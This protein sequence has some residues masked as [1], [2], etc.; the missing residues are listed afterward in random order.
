MVSIEHVDV[1]QKA[2]I[3]QFID[4]PYRLYEG[5]SQWVPPFRRDVAE[6]LDPARHP[7]YEHSTADFFL[8]IRDGRVVGRIAALENRNYNR[9][10]DTRTGQFYL[11]ESEEDDEAAAALFDTVF[12]WARRRGLDSVVGPKG[13]SPFDG[14]GVLQSGFEQ[15]QMMNMTN[16]NHPYYQRL[17]EAAGFVKEVDFVS[18]CLDARQFHLPPR[19]AHIAGRVQRQRS[20][21]VVEFG[22]RRALRRWG[23]KIGRTYNKTFVDNWEYVPLTER[24]ISYVVN[25]L[26]LVA[27][28]RLIKIVVQGEDVVGFA[29]GF[30]DVSAA[31]QRANGRLTPFTVLD[32]L[33]EMRRTR[34]ISGNGIG[35]L[36]GYQGR[37]GNALLY[38]TMEKTLREHHFD[39]YELTQVAE[40]AVQMRRDLETLGGRP[41]KNHRVYRRWL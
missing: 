15:R 26:M 35:M 37:G 18:C 22:S 11:F 8:A 39:Y 20:L 32:L 28:P 25:N 5:C 31:M 36:P 41:Y 29:F 10:H 2:R 17:V 7:F 6:M 27:N 23:L 40:T 38:V 33:R 16:Y 24:E 4:F 12:D 21:R 34:W 30:P 1:T 19:V 3:K 9:H 13:F 14:Y